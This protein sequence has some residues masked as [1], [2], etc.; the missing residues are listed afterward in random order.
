MGVTN[1]SFLAQTATWLG[2]HLYETINLAFEH[3]G[4][5]FI[6]VLQRCSA[7]SEK[8][9]GEGARNIPLA[10]LESDDGIPV[11]N[12]TKRMGTVVK[13]NYEDIGLAQAA[14]R[15]DYS[16]FNGK[17]GNS[18][19]LNLSKNITEPIGLLYR[20]KNLPSYEKIRYDKVIKKDPGGKLKDLE[21]ELDNYTI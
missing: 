1:V 17:L 18:E 12:Y 2:P 11:D 6:R 9:Y 3:K 13:H 14:A 15:K 8:L 16:T 7:Y 19:N 10:V 21:T 4:L 5:S 20:N